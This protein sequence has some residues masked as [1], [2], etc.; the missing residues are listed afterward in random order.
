MYDLGNNFIR[1]GSGL[2]RTPPRHPDNAS[3]SNSPEEK[4][5]RREQQPVKIDVQRIDGIQKL[6]EEDEQPTPITWPS[7]VDNNR[8]SPMGNHLE[9]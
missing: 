4:Y 2:E 6:S 1:K 5:E 7:R 3:Y 8:Q 9:R